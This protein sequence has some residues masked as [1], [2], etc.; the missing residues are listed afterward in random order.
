MRPNAVY[1]CNVLKIWEKQYNTMVTMENMNK[2]I[3]IIFHA[4]VFILSNKFQE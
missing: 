2:D 3:K 4:I 1:T